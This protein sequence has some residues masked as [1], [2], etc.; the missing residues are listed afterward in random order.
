M[1]VASLKL[2]GERQLSERNASSKNK[3]VCIYPELVG[4]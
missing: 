4:M 1:K 2:A 3:D